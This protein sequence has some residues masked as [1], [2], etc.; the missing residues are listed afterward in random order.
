MA[1]AQTRSGGGTPPPAT[2]PAT[3]PN[4][5]FK[6]GKKLRDGGN[7]TNEFAAEVSG[8]K[9]G[10]D[11]DATQSALYDEQG[12]DPYEVANAQ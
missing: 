9:L 2:P 10:V 12:L 4:A 3:D 6:D 1:T 5:D 8:K 7:S 11:K